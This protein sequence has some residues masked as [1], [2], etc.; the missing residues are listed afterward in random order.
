M[1]ARP[2]RGLLDASHLFSTSYDTKKPAPAVAGAGTV[3]AYPTDCAFFLFYFS[4]LVSLLFFSFLFSA[5][6]PIKLE[7]LASSL[8]E[9]ESA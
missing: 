7:G 1:Q 9:V 5:V 3:G 8:A 6:F 4:S 2:L